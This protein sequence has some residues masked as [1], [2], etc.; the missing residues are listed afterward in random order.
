MKTPFSLS[1]VIPAYNEEKNIKKAIVQVST[2]LERLLQAKKLKS[3]QLIVVDDGSRDQTAHQVKQLQKTTPHLKL[4]QNRPNRGY[5]GALKA[6]FQKASQDLIAWF[7]AD[8]QFDFSEITKLLEKVDQADIIAGYRT[9]RQDHLIRK[10]NALGWNLT[11]RLLFG[12]LCRDVDCGFKLFKRKILKNIPQ[13]TS[14]RGGMIDPEFLYLA[15]SRGYTI[16][17]VPLTH[18]PRKA[19]Q[20]TGANLKVIVN[21]FRDLFRLWYNLRIRR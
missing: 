20:S 1:V 2:K 10:L 19:G 4:V 7:P 3:Y 15:K 12:Y 5:G 17:D 14:E 6:G 11:I 9:N 16:A 18:Y 21:S 13:L 8:L